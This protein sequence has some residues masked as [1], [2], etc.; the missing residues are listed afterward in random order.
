MRVVTFNTRHAV[1]IDSTIA[2][3]RDTP[4]LQRADIVAL[5]EVDAAATERIARSLGMEYVYYPATRHPKFGRDFG[6][7]ILTRWPIV[8][9]RKLLL[10]HLGRFR[11]T[12]RTVTAVTITVNGNAVRVY[13]AH[14]GTA[15]EIGPRQKREQMQVIVDDAAAHARVV[16][17]GDMNGHGVG[18]VLRAAGYQWPT[19]HNPKTI[20]FGNWDHVFLK[21]I[22]LAHD[23]AIGVVRDSRR[24]SDHRAVWAVIAVASPAGSPGESREQDPP[25]QIRWY[26]AAAAAAGATALML[27]DE[28]MQRAVQRSRSPTTDDL[29]GVFRRV[30]QPEVFGTVSAGLIGVGLVGDR[31]QLTRAGGRL[32]GSLVIAGT[33]TFAIKKVVGR[34]RPSADLGA[35]VFRPFTHNESLPSGHTAMAF[36]LATSLADE[37]N[38]LWLTVGLYALATGTA[39]SRMNDDR[40]WVSDVSLGALIGTTAA[41]LMNGRWRVFGLAPPRLLVDPEGGAAFGWRLAL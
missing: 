16:V 36:A 41:K 14:L 21:G 4:A 31:P 25:H 20:S 33:G 13:S 39:W 32:V 7:A 2:L 26:E 38:R 5:Q 29:A 15:A 19:E 12:V 3:L 9:D 18:K 40:H 17:L 37:L 35:F 23:G 1:E 6:N 30:G 28:P 24:A 11:H 34:A 8:E 10:P 22:A 27:V